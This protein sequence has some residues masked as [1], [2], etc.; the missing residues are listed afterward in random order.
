[1][2][3]RIVVGVDI[4]TTKVCAVVASADE[5]NRVNILGVGVAESDGLNRGVVVNID[6][7]VA[8][9]QAALEEAERAAGVQVRQV[10]VGI[11]GDHIQSFQSRGVITISNRDGEITRRDVERLLEDTTHVA[12]PADR[13]ILHV[14]PQEFIVD[15][16]DGVADPVG[17]SGVRL[18]ANVHIITGLVSAA[19]NVYRCVEKAGYEVAD[20]VLEPLASSFA[21][22]H[23]DEKEI[24]VALI[25]IGGGTTDIAVFEDNT[26]RH[27]GVIAVAGNKVTDDLRKG[28]GIMRDQA[29]R[30]KC[31]FGV[32]MVDLIEE[33]EEITIPG[34]GGR[35]EK[36]ISRSTLAQIIQP[37]MEE[38]LEIAAIE[39]KRSGYARHLAAGVVLTGGGALIPGTAELAA[40]VLG[41]EARIGSPMG[42]SGGMVAEVSDPKFATAVGLVLYGLRPE[43][44]G[45]PG[46]SQEVHARSA[47]ESIPGQML[48][49]KI[50]SRMKAWFNEL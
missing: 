15:G 5:M 21:V 4:G 42:L 39:I 24:G 43:L 45:T 11:A 9:L 29:E 37:R 3:E 38:I 14:I 10:I 47:G 26:I 36:R 23:P 32:A 41:M 12:L 20:L 48:F 31:R 8:S 25:D 44:I 27:T 19:K 17:M 34:I 22:L 50:A 40:D 33:D 6:K 35:P 7:T 30:L 16:Q 13:E 2:N 46:L 28:L 49:R 18:E 1:M